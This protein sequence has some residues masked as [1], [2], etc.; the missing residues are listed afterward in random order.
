MAGRG[1]KTP[2]EIADE[3]GFPVIHLAFAQRGD[4]V[5]HPTGPLGICDGV[6]SHFLMTD[7]VTRFP[8]AACVKAW[9]VR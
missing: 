3:T 4:V 1:I 2:A 5:Q 7:G 6:F 9:A 8:T